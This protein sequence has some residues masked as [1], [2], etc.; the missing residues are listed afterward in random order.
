MSFI[1]TK[2]DLLCYITKDVSICKDD[3]CIQ[4]CMHPKNNRYVYCND[5]TKYEYLPYTERRNDAIKQYIELYGAEDL[6]DL[7]L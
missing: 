1:I 5:P 2:S 4:C 7:L 3:T 6:F